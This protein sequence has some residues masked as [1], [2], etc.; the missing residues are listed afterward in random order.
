MLYL[1]SYDIPSDKRR[2]KL[3]N[4]LKNFGDRVQY[5]VFECI[6]SSVLYEKM[7]DGI[8]KLI[9]KKE[10]SVRVYTLCLACEK[11]VRIFGQGEISRIEKVYII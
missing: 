7:V 4:M 6:L 9:D 11:H 8:N 10:D 3:S 2:V 1:V 5:S